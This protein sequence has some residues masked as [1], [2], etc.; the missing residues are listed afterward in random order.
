M[1]MRARD[2]P[3]L[4]AS[5][6][7]AEI[8][9]AYCQKAHRAF[10]RTRRHG[11]RHCWSQLDEYADYHKVI[12][13]EKRNYWQNRIDKA[14]CEYD[15]YKIV[16]WHKLGPAIRSPPLV[17]GGKSIEDTTE[18]AEALR[19][20][21]L[22]RLSEADDLEYDTVSVQTVPRHHTTWDGYISGAS[23]PLPSPQSS[24]QPLPTYAGIK[25]LARTPTKLRYRRW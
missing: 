11:E 15:L 17:V 10:R 14:T 4:A 3:G 20:A 19:A 9:I 5:Q 21:L 25:R 1:K 23:L 6:V 24:P 16:Q 2:G 22:E 8:R 18:K 13:R 7:I 12:R